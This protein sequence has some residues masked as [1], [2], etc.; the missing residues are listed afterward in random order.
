MIHCISVGLRI[1]RASKQTYTARHCSPNRRR[2]FIMHA[3]AFCL[4]RGAMPSAFTARLFAPT[5]LPRDRTTVATREEKNA[6]RQK[7]TDVD[8]MDA[9]TCLGRG[10]GALDTA[11]RTNCERFVNDSATHILFLNVVVCGLRLVAARGRIVSPR[12]STFEPS[13]PSFSC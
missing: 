4:C 2:R 6:A 8:M 11:E 10:N 5:R 1:D 3:R 7:W 12:S 9:H 13:P